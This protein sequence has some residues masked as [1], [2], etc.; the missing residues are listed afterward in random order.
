MEFVLYA[1]GELI[2][3]LKDL[4]WELRLIMAYNLVFSDLASF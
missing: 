4:A 1:F 3:V 2:N